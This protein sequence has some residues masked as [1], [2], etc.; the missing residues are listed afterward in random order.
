M[1]EEHGLLPRWKVGSKALKDSSRS[2]VI[3]AGKLSIGL[4]RH[5]ALLFKVNFKLFSVDCMLILCYLL[6]ISLT[7]TL[8]WILLT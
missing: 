1:D 3:S 4:C 6:W 7:A 8:L 2:V 5:R